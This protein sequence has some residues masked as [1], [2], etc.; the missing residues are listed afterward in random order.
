M[1]I[2]IIIF[3]NNTGMDVVAGKK[4]CLQ[5]ISTCTVRSHKLRDTDTFSPIA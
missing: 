3:K 4:M 1:K 5:F 2:Q